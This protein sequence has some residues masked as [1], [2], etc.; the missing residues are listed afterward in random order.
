[1]CIKWVTF[2]VISLQAG[3]FFHS[4]QRIATAQQREVEA[5]QVG[6]G[7]DSPLLLEQVC[8]ILFDSF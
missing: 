3:E 4:A 7:L 5:R 1:M 6:D 2:F 8:I